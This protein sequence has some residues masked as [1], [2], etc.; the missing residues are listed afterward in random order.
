MVVARSRGF[1][2][3]KGGGMGE[4]G[5]FWVLVPQDSE[6]ARRAAAAIYTGLYI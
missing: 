6:V 3:R 5:E 1:G 2:F 4:T